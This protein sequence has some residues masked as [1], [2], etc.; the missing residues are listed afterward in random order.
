MPDFAFNP[1]RRSTNVEDVREGSQTSKL[2]ELYGP[3]KEVTLEGQL[4]RGGSE[5]EGVVRK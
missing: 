3:G 4:F 2:R 1:L 5:P